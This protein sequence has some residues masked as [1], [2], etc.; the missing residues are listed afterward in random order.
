MT[1]RTWNG[2]SDT[3]SNAAD[4]SPAGVPVAGDT[5]V[6]NSG[7]VNL[8]TLLSGVIIDLNEAS[9]ATTSTTLALNNATL[10]ATSSLTVT[11][12]QPSVTSTPA[13]ISV[14]GTSTFAGTESFNGTTTNFSIAAGSTLVNAGTLNFY[15]SSPTTTGG[16]TLQNSGTIALV[17]PAN[18]VTVP[19]FSDAI[20]G[21]GTIALGKFAALQINGS[22]SSGQ[23][24]VFNDGASG[25]ETLQLNALGSFAATINGFS[26]SDLL[27]VVLPS[28][29]SSATYTSTGSSSGT[30]SLFSGATLQ[31][32]I[33]FTGN[34]TLSSFTITPNALS[35]GQ[36]NVQISTSVVNAVSAGLPSGYQG[37]GGST[38]GGTTTPVT[39]PVGALYRFFDTKYGTHFFTSDIG[40][41]NTV[42]ATRPD[43]TEETNGFGDV[44][45]SDP[46]AVAVY[47]F[48][49]NNFGTHFFTANAGERDTV[50]ATRP[51][52]TYEPG[53]TFYEHSTAQS[54]DVAVYRL[55]DQGT[56]TQFL[57]GDQGEYNGITTPGSGTYRADLHSEGVAFYAPS[58]SFT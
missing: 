44:A 37:G 47:R 45:Q 52:L 49:D 25:S 4:W 31:G 14:T 56:G 55:F 9:G 22:V 13:V 12:S 35:N 27:A 42:L 2:T 30:L 46:N 23:T 16:G 11:N 54:G 19:V 7:T 41:R 40:E 58:G 48:F 53:S 36:S 34:Y 8:A 10:D 33:N 28:T 18:R 6:I 26:T 5:A 24:L 3:Y 43:L 21:T 29:Y 50:I 1:T 20:T 39:T 57:T 15:S 32:S 17:N 51:D 38:S